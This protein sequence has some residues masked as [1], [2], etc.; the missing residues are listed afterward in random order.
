MAKKVLARMG[1]D[2]ECLRRLTSAGRGKALKALRT[3]AAAKARWLLAPLSLSLSLSLSSG[4]AR[5]TAQACSPR[6][7]SWRA[8]S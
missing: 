5:A 1:I 7:T 6:R 4:A 8:A 2:P 3:L